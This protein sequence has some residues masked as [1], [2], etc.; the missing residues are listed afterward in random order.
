MPVVDTIEEK[1]KLTGRSA[2][3]SDE[4]GQESLA[5]GDYEEAIK[6]FK[7]AI[8]Q[9]DPNDIKSR[10]NLAGA[11]EYSDQGP[12][13]MRQYMKALKLRNDEPEPYVGM[14]SIL[15][16]YSRFRQAAEE[17]Q[18]AI[19]LDPEN[20]YLHSQLAQ[21]LREM[22]E[23]KRALV[24]A[25]GAVAAAPDQ[26]YY[27]YWIGDLLMSMERWSEALDSL[28]AAIELS[29]GDDHLFFKSAIC[30]WAEDKRAQAIKAIRLASDLDPSKHLYH[31]LLAVFLKAEG[32]DED[33]KLE[34]PRAA[35]MDRF[36]HETL[37]VILQ[38]LGMA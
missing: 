9:R 8:E 23:K 3:E 17:L 35:Q 22:G 32:Q 11:L 31:G 18:T 25:M 1:E 27:H 4:L 21:L 26:P 12:M 33:A 15:K 16:R 30:F 38:Q 19:E 5:G 36:D 6:H 20:A 29:P 34:E 2:D 13:A 14:A 7:R 10:I 24:A 37:Q 28:Q